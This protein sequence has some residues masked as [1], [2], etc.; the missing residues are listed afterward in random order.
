MA[1]WKKILREDLAVGSGLITHSAGGSSSAVTLTLADNGPNSDV[2]TITLGDN[3]TASSIS[4]AGFELDVTG[5]ATVATSGDYDDLSN[6]PTIPSAIFSTIAVTGTA[7]QSDVIADTATDT[8]TLNAGNNISI[9]TDASGDEITFAVT[10]LADVAT[11][12]D[13][14]DLINLPTIGNGTITFTGDAYITPTNSFTLNQTGNQAITFA[15]AI[16][17]NTATT[18]GQTPAFGATFNVVS[19][20][21]YNAAGHVTAANIGTVTLPTPSANFIT[22]VTDTA[23]QNGIDL[24]VSSGALSAVATNLSTTSNVTFNDVTVSGNLTVNGDTTQLNVTNLAVEDKLIKLADV[25]SPSTTT[26]SGAGIQVETS[27]T[28]AE[29]PELL[30]TST[31][32]LA[33]WTLSDHAST[34]NQDVPISVMKVAAGAPTGEVYGGGSFYYDTTAKILYVDIT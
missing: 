33:G 1:T 4:D 26:G 27:T 10:G 6:T 14:D 13:Y 16:Y 28:E 18:N 20:L 23:G 32:A 11:S 7:G 34:S 21:T 12:G 5:L 19:G 17:S 9:T 2:I 22:E 15:H 3:L 24:T 25:T 30:W 8:L 29:W 31:A